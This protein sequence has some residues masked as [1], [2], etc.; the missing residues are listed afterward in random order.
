MLT[1]GPTVQFEMAS[2]LIL[3]ANFV[4][5]TK[6]TISITN[7]PAGLSVSNAAF[8]V[9]GKAGDNW[10]VANVFYSLNNGS[11]SNA[12]TG[13]NWT[14]WSAAVTLVPGTNTIAAYAVDPAAMPP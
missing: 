8:T 2:N 12:V 9:K 4:A 3:Q 11:W 10:Q 13:N 7:V 5:L 14:N 6:P 1:N